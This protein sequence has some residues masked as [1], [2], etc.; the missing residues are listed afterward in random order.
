LD[1]TEIVSN[2]VQSGSKK[3]VRNGRISIW[4]VCISLRVPA[5]PGDYPREFKF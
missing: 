2:H 5:E 1:T 4:V 3:Q